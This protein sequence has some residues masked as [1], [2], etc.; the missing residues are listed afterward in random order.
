MDPI[1][2]SHEQLTQSL[3]HEIHRLRER[4][5]SAAFTL[6]Q[7]AETIFATPSESA[8]REYIDQYHHFYHDSE[9]L[10]PEHE[11]RVMAHLALT[12]DKIEE[13][14][15]TAV[16]EQEK[17]VREKS[18]SEMYVSAIL[19]VYVPEIKESFDRQKKLM[20][21]KDLLGEEL[22]SILDAWIEEYEKFGVKTDE[23]H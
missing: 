21:S 5:P 14:I 20:S 4:L 6:P 11:L 13:N 16:A 3:A 7:T 17:G 18:Q 2:D 1:G 10:P 9:K 19:Y 22:K 8:L 12:L 23:P 15:R